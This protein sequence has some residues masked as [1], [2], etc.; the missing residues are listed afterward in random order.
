MPCCFC[1]SRVYVTISGSCHKIRPTEMVRRAFLS[2]LLLCSSTVFAGR[3]STAEFGPAT[4]ADIRDLVTEAFTRRYTADKWSIFI[5][6]AVN[7]SSNG[8]LHC[9]AIAGVTPK[10]SDKFPVRSFSYSVQRQISSNESGAE[11]RELAAVCARGAIE[12]MMAED[13]GLIY[14]SPPK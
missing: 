11:R 14:V 6:S 12:A 7:R 10:G 2:L 5:Y 1:V 4:A 9:Y 8:T 13:V 3:F